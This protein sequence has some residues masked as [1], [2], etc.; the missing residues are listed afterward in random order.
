MFLRSSADA[1]AIIVIIGEKQFHAFQVNRPIRGITEFDPTVSGCILKAAD[2]V[3]DN[4]RK[5]L[6]GRIV[7]FG[8][9]A[10]GK[11]QRAK[12]CHK[13]CIRNF[14]IISGL[15]GKFGLLAIQNERNPVFVIAERILFSSSIT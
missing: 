13:K 9:L 5:L 1:F 10:G 11:D 4:S 6:G 8:I 12:Q 2:F 15:E 7:L 14:H 3:N